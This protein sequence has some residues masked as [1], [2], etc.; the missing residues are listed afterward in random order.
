MNTDVVENSDGRAVEQKDHIYLITNQFSFQIETGFECY[1]CF[2]VY[3]G[4]RPTHRCS[5]KVQYSTHVILLCGYL[6]LEIAAHI[7]HFCY[8]VQF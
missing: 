7:S 5:A 8:I 6:S 4:K 2:K 1:H 3:K